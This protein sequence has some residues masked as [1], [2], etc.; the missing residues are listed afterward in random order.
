MEK[1]K[2]DR[3]ET[4]DSE[5][6]KISHLWQKTGR[7]AELGSE[8]AVKK[9]VVKP[10]DLITDPCKI[11]DDPVIRKLFRRFYP[12]DHSIIVQP[13]FKIQQWDGPED[14]E[15]EQVEEYETRSAG[16]YDDR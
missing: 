9:R 13:D 6:M 4:L 14:I 10:L 2:R 15:Q 11:K 8:D 7:N 12:H 16:A 5:L 1:N 3:M